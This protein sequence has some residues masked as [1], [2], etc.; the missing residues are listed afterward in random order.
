MVRLV[1]MARLETC[2]IRLFDLPETGSKERN[3]RNAQEYVFAKE[4]LIFIPSVKGNL[5]NFKPSPRIM[6]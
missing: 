4:L 1:K 2:D 3:H 5:F 6:I